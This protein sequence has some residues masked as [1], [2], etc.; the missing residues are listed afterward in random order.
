MFRI[1][2][3]ATVIA[4][5]GKLGQCLSVKHFLFLQKLWADSGKQW[6]WLSQRNRNA[7]GGT[8]YDVQQ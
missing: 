7:A 2:E 3:A 6:A 5:A 4:V 8:G 1:S